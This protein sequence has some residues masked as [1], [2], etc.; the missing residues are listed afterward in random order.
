MFSRNK[1]IVFVVAVALMV[2]AVVPAAAQDNAN[3][4][5]VTGIGSATAT[6][7]IVT[8][9]VG[10]EAFSTDVRSAFAQSNDTLRQVVEALRELGIAASDINT[11]NLSVF[12]SSRFSMMGEEE[13]GFNVSNTVRITVRDI[14][15]IEAV[16]NAAIESGANQ[17]YGLGFAISDVNEVESAARAAAIESARA[18]AEQLA[19]LTGVSLGEVVAVSEVDSFGFFP[20]ARLQMDG[21]G[22]GGAFVEPGQ[23]TV[24][25][26]VQV[27][28][29]I[30]R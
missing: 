7:D 16:L 2:M 18:R 22:G 10:V 24:T 23:Q 1:W 30:V 4:I 26:A 20:M 6:P 5:R 15:Q 8:V 13:R 12:S 28:Y 14:S 11:S 29:R 27:T 19:A 3:T 9:E 17:V 25:I 21:M